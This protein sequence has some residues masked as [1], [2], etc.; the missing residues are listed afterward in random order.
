MAD[1]VWNESGKESAMADGVWNEPGKESLC[2]AVIND[3]LPDAIGD[4]SPEASTL[5]S[6]SKILFLVL[7][8]VLFYV[9]SALLA[10]MSLVFFL[11]GLIVNQFY[12]RICIDLA[13]LALL[14]SSV[15]LVVCAAFEE[16]I[17][18]SGTK[19]GK[20]RMVDGPWKESA[21]ESLCPEGI[22]E[23]LPDDTGDVIGLPE[24]TKT[25]PHSKMLRISSLV[26]SLCL[27]KV[28]LAAMS[29]IFVLCGIFIN[30]LYFWV[31]VI[32][33][34]LALLSAWLHLHEEYFLSLNKI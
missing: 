18:S 25:F 30:P 8:F 27:T 22:Q 2:P 17:S 32:L 16:R 34:V 9:A 15:H 21:K 31:S 29:V 13:S 28:L 24:Q 20:E 3:S 6:N 1:G 19:L 7:L 12:F 23:N 5:A 14:A 33:A 26:V 4:A 11:C 10:V